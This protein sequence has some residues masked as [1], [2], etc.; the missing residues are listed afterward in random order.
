MLA[1]GLAVRAVGTEERDQIIDT[2]N[3]LDTST[4]FDRE[5]A[6]CLDYDLGQI[7]MEISE[8]YDKN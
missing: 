7:E 3:E 6:E 8:Y 5:E 1:V 4:Y 2:I